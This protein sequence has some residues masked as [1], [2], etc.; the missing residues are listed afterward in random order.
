MT[1]FPGR[2]WRALTAK[3]KTEGGSWVEV[4]NSLHWPQPS[5]LFR[6]LHGAATLSQQFMALSSPL[7]LTRREMVSNRN[8]LSQARDLAANRVG[9]LAARAPAWSLQEVGATA[10]SDDLLSEAARVY[11]VLCEVL[12]IKPEQSSVTQKPI[13]GKTSKRRATS[14]QKPEVTPKALADIIHKSMPEV[15]AVLKNTRDEFGRPSVITRF[16]FTVLFLPPAVYYGA[17]AIVKNKEWIREQAQNAKDTVKGFFVKWVWEPIEEIA[18]TM[19]GGGEGLS[20]APE[21]VKNDEE[22][23]KR[24]VVDFGRDVYHLDSSQLSA[25]EQK[26]QG[27]DMEAV[28]K[29][30]EKEIQS[31]IKSALFGHLIR[32]LLIQVQKTKVGRGSRHNADSRLTSLW[33]YSS[34]T[35]SSAPSS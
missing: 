9:I 10:S 25:L 24:M 32:T 19:K 34:S 31:P 6:P 11:G 1:G 33:H 14:P 20:F 12:N 18:K 17:S 16:W 35:S 30:Y 3:I 13:V 5:Q 15:R 7:T 2:V 22:S 28:L 8:T 27:G 21:T 4:L 26:V 29:A 23:L